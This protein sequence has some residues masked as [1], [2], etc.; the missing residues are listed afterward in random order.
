MNWVLFLF[1]RV[2]VPLQLERDIKRHTLNAEDAEDK[3]ITSKN[4][5]AQVVVT[6]QREQENVFHN[7]ND[8]SKTPDGAKKLLGGEEKV[9]EGCDI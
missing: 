8:I 5:N 2:V 1:H 7:L 6:Q 3:P 9:R 4:T